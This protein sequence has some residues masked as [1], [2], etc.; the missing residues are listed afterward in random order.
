MDYDFDYIV[1]GSGFGGSVSALRLAEKGYKVAVLEM[2]LRYKA[3]DFAKT[4]WNLPKYLWFPKLFCYGIQNISILKHVII[5]HGT[6]VGGG[7]LVY[8]N[9]LLVPPEHVFKSS[10]WSH[11]EKWNEV[12]PA[13]YELAKKM[14][15]VNKCP[16]V[17]ET[18]KLLEE[19]AKEIG[20]FKKFQSAEVGVLFGDKP[21]E[22]VGDPYFGGKGPKRNTCN[23][24]GC[25]MT[26][27]KNNAKNTLDKNYLY[28]AEK[29]GVE[30]FDN[31]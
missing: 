22:D 26:G 17:P 21:G 2:G 29:L 10:A 28:L 30:I 23:Y 7:S 18:D 31:S 27:C 12:L 25:C 16:F 4:N 9:T 3:E 24:C 19:T 14:L 8:A 1:I 15:G 11:L 20:A 13:K 6:G 5:F